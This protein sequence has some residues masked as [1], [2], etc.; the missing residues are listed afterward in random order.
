MGGSWN[1]DFLPVTALSSRWQ[2]RAVTQGRGQGEVDPGLAH[3]GGRMVLGKVVHGRM[4]RGRSHSVVDVQ[5]S[6]ATSAT[7]RSDHAYPRLFI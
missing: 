6:T 4:W 7:R 1:P 3:S 5:L 2:S